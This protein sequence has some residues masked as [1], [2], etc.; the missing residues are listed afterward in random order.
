MDEITIQVEFSGISRVMT[1]ESGISISLK[2]GE[3]VADVVRKLGLKFPKLV[4][5][6]IEKDGETLIPS[7]LFS[8]NG[9]KILHETDLGYQPKNGDRLIL[10]SLLA[11][12]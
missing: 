7:N 9:E 2:E 4:G 11:G 10:L 8:V 6:I 1:G 3:T 12:G 5:E